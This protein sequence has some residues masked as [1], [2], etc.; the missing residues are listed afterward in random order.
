MNL[1]LEEL[2]RRNLLPT[3]AEAGLL[4]DLL[5]VDLGVERSRNL[6]LEG[7]DADL[8]RESLPKGS[9]AKLSRRSLLNDLE[10]K[11]VDSLLL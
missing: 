2:S 9:A 7:A 4:T 10:V 1:R 3:G 11:V 5:S 8:S 6:L